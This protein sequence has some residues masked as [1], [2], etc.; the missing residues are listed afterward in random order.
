MLERL[1]G[2]GLLKAGGRQRTDSTH[3]LAAVRT[4]NR[5]EFV[6]ETL[7]AALEALPVAAPTWL[8]GLVTPEGAERSGPHVDDHRFPKGEEVREQWP[9]QAGRDGFFLLQAVHAPAAPGW[10]REIEAVQVLRVSWVQQ[11]HRDEKRGC[12]G[13]RARTSRRFITGCARPMTPMPV[14]GSSVARAGPATRRI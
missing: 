9:Q 10:L 5:M 11:Y 13:G 4:L 3:V 6:G 1:R 14:T 7:R 8:S 2:L 12:A